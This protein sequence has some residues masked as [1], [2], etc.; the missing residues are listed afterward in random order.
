MGF[1]IS[2]AA[3][4]KN[5]SDEDGK[6]VKGGGWF[7]IHRVVLSLAALLGITGFILIFVDH[8]GFVRNPDNTTHAVLGII[9]TSLS[10]INPIMGL[11]RPGVGTPKRKYFNFFHF[12]V[13]Y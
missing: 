6:I 3:V 7:Q 2:S 13:G 8:K 10:I 11:L 5:I 12:L 9:V 1:S 4:L